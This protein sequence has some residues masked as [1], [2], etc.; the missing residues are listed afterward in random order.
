[1]K[2]TTA[3]FS[4]LAATAA[5]DL[6]TS[7]TAVAELATTTTNTLSN[8][9]NHPIE[10]DARD[11]GPKQ[12]GPNGRPTGDGPT[13]R[14]PPQARHA[15][16]RKKSTSHPTAEER[17]TLEARHKDHDHGG[18]NSTFNPN[19]G[20]PEEKRGAT[21]QTRHKGHGKGGKN[22]TSNNPAV[23][24]A[25]ERGLGLEARR[26]HRKNSTATA[27]TSGADRAGGKVMG[28]NLGMLVTFGV[29]VGL[30]VVLL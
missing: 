15:G 2:P 3:L 18:K 10:L 21:P 28:L 22:S 1:M 17:G 23:A 4:L 6:G 11:T 5:A 26:R 9:T 12:V 7:S 13:R 25:E 24:E 14:P 29:G 20:R 16:H 19:S 30:G 8:P 27:A